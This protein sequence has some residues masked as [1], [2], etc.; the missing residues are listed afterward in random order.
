MNG[1]WTIDEENKPNTRQAKRSVD[2][3]RLIDYAFPLYSGR[4]VSA[5]CGDGQWESAPLTTCTGSDGRGS[6][7]YSAVVVFINVDD[8]HDNRNVCVSE[9]LIYHLSTFIPSLPSTC[10]FSL[11]RTFL[12]V[13]NIM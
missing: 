5:Y 9:L 3:D 11:L 2:C 10:L 13:K 7:L 4:G 8:V 1:G 6:Y 12:K